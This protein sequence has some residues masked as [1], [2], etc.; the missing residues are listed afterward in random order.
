M[1][2]LIVRDGALRGQRFEVDSGEVT[3]GREDTD[4]VIEDDTEVSRNHAV[5]RP[6]TDGPEIEDLGST[7]GTFVNEQQISGSHRLSN[8][9]TVRVG[10]TRFD[11]EAEEDD[12][13]KTSVS[14]LVMP[15]TQEHAPVA[16]ARRATPPEQPSSSSSDA[17]AQED[18]ALSGEQ[19]SSAAAWPP[20]SPVGEPSASESDDSPSSAP[21]ADPETR[22][23]TSELPTR[24][25]VGGGAV[26][27]AGSDK[28][29]LLIGAAVLGVLIVGYLLYSALAGGPPSTEDYVASVNDICRDDM[30][31]VGEFNLNRAGGTERAASLIGGLTEDID[32]LERPEEEGGRI[33]AFVS[34]FQRVGT[35]FED[36]ST[37]QSANN[38]RRAREADTK[39]ERSTRRFNRA[40]RE[41]GANQCALR[42]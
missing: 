7:N 27:R 21:A 33:D 8:G 36:L 26:Q 24:S 3:I 42:G 17:Q 23:P 19:P 1:A 15:P 6:A 32:E 11:V 34:S 16:P 13:N 25:K 30:A 2:T 41:L 12:P 18:P 14:G 5:V 28:R 40:A 39:L 9:D 4:V 10:Q 31:R 29:P 20:S 22:A 38:E 37:S 35:G